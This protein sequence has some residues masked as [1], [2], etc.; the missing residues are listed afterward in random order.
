MLDFDL[1]KTSGVRRYGVRASVG[2]DK[3]KSTAH[4]ILSFFVMKEN[5]E[6]NVQAVA[7]VVARCNIHVDAGVS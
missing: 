5:G 7:M 2:F 6:C 4:N 3:S 1:D